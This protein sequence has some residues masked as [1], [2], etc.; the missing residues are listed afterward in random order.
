MRY[1]FGW[2]LLSVALV[3]SGCQGTAQLSPAGP[4]GPRAQDAGYCYGE[5]LPPLPGR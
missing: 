1:V 5:A 2:M 4:C 3:A